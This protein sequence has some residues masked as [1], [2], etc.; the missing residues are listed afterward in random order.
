M[1]AAGAEAGEAAGQNAVFGVES[2]G[3]S[4]IPEDERNMS[5]N[6]IGPLW[7]GANINMF[8]VSIG[9]VAI[10]LG[11]NLWQAL[12]A[13]VIGNLPY[14]Y[15]G[16][17][18]IGSVRAGLPV[19]TFSRSVY[20]LNGNRI[21]AG[22]TWAASVCFEVFNAVFGSLAW[23]SLLALLG[24]DKSG[25]PEKLSAIVIQLA[26]GGGI[27]VFGQ[28]TMVFLQK[29]FAAVL[30]AVFLLVL[31]WTVPEVHWSRVGAGHPGLAG[32]GLLAA[33]MTA[34]GVI[35]SQPVSYLYNGPDWL[36]YLPSRTPGRGIFHR[37]F[38][39]TFLPSIVLC[40]AGALWASLGDMSD[41]VAGLKPLLP[42]WLY[43]AFVM[44]VILGSVANNAPTFYSS[45]L[46]LQAAGL[47]LSRWSATLLDIT[48]SAAAVLYILF[49][50][51]LSTVLNDFVSLLVA[52]SGPYA[53]VWLCDGLIRRWRFDLK[54]IHPPPG[55][56]PARR[57][58]TRAWIAYGLGMTAAALTMKSP[59][60]QGPVNRLLHGMDLS[61]VLGLAV[62]A[63]AYFLLSRSDRTRT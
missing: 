29:F 17:A 57:R 6:A 63:S 45:G 62:A 28:A 53:G 34:C 40:G 23:L 33:F 2:R 48:V 36:R 14:A 4:H 22:L 27:A 11:L 35:A 9:C 26:I 8:S 56:A 16:L 43:V 7:L 47:K 44:S 54:D 59:L 13:C 25:T 5:L 50:Q 19:T 3:F 39:W 24:F 32:L 61:W 20:G 55:Q 60:Y 10:T 58:T 38:W 12:A 49:V 15:L 41:P 21:H 46:S 1:A 51:D 31:A 42:P 52:W 18:S 30:G 37:V